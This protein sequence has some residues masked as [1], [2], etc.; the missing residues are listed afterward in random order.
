MK[1][2]D[3]TRGYGFIGRD[4]EVDL[5]VH[6]SAVEPAG[7][8]PSAEKPRDGGEGDGE[9][10]GEDGGERGGGTAPGEEAAPLRRGERVSFEVAEGARGLQARAVRRLG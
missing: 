9:R 7:G 2:F 6:A 10:R 5:F 3:A 1:W 4:G 8:A